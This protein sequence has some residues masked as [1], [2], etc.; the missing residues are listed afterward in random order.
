MTIRRGANS[1]RPINLVMLQE[2]GAHL[3]GEVATAILA[4]LE[5]SDV[6]QRLPTGVRFS[7]EDV[8][9]VARS[10]KNKAL[11]IIAG[12]VEESVQKAYFE[13]YFERREIL[14]AVLSEPGMLAP[15]VLEAIHERLWSAEYVHQAGYEAHRQ[16]A[17]RT[18][19]IEGAVRWIE[20]ARSARYAFDVLGEHLA[21]QWTTGASGV[22][23]LQ[24]LCTTLREARLGDCIGTLCTG[25]GRALG[26]RCSEQILA[27]LCEA[28]GAVGE[29]WF[30]DMVA[31]TYGSA[32][33]ITVPLLEL[34]LERLVSPER[35]HDYQL[36]RITEGTDEPQYAP[37]ELRDARGR[38][39]REAYLRLAECF[40]GA[41][42]PVISGRM[43]AP[44][45][46]EATEVV[47]VALAS[48]LSILAHGLLCNAGDGRFQVELD[49]ERFLRALDVYENGI[50]IA[51]LTSRRPKIEARGAVRHI[52]NGANIED[53]CRLARH[54]NSGEEYIMH[55]YGSDVGAT[56]RY[57]PN[58]GEL[59]LLLS[60][61]EP[62][63]RMAAFRRLL[64]IWSDEGGGGRNR[65]PMPNRHPNG[66]PERRS[67]LIG[68]AL[69]EYLESA[70]EQIPASE[71]AGCSELTREFMLRIFWREFGETPKAWMTAIALVERADVPLSK[72][73]RA[74]RLLR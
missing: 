60:Q 18:L 42:H 2:H 47:D 57:V 21:E 45:D 19:P 38:Y 54:V 69:F 49:R 13:L 27:I 65:G 50:W 14:E 61:Y 39:T 58:P 22:E 41:L 32:R 11:L 3:P 72:V 70:I 63:V 20:T 66:S 71:I 8:A 37:S 31:A 6:P 4:G 30:D 17:A 55:L 7:G 52:P 36:R 24:N 34:L 33:S 10:S 43:P 68:A 46:M 40:P 35:F 29:R 64:R 53:V 28:R 12:C 67:P 25:F 15:D 44:E 74:G 51:S 16:L 73:V 62:T 5:E 48:N 26:E 59:A 9:G 56:P 1:N 23:V